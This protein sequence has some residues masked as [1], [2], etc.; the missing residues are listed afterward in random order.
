MHHSQ[1]IYVNLV[2]SLNLL[3]VHASV[4]RHRLQNVAVWSQPIYRYN[5]NIVDNPLVCLCSGKCAKYI[6]FCFYLSSRSVTHT[7]QL[8]Q[9]NKFFKPTIRSREGLASITEHKIHTGDKCYRKLA[10]P[11]NPI[12]HQDEIQS[13]KPQIHLVRHNEYTV[14]RPIDLGGT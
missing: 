10:D 4:L 5:C 11:Y 7:S 13:N 3:P 14:A 1:V 9:L 2:C 12:D 6:T 8:L